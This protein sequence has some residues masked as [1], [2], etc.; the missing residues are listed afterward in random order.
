MNWIPQLFFLFCVVL[1]GSTNIE[2]KISQHE[3]ALIRQSFSKLTHHL[4]GYP[5]DIQA[6]G[7]QCVECVIGSDFCF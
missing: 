5:E 7:A 6:G 4:L 2:A 1:L 3:K